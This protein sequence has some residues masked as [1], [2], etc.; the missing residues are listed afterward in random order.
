MV[1]AEFLSSG[2]IYELSILG[3]ENFRYRSAAEFMPHALWLLDKN[4]TAGPSSPCRCRHC[5]QDKGAVR[6]KGRLPRRSAARGLIKSTSSR[7]PT[8][9]RSSMK[10]S[11]PIHS[12][13]SKNTT[14]DT[15]RHPRRP[16]GIVDGRTVLARVRIADPITAP[17]ADIDVRSAT[18]WPVL[19]E[20]VWCK[21]HRPIAWVEVLIDF[22]PGII[23]E[24]VD[25]SNEYQVTLIGITHDVSISLDA[26]VPY[27]TYRTEEAL[28]CRIQRCCR[29][30]TRIKLLDLDRYLGIK[31][32][33]SRFAAVSSAFLFAIKFSEHLATVWSWTSKLNVTDHEPAVAAPTPSRYALRSRR[34][35]EEGYGALWW[36][37]ECI[38]KWQL[39]RLKMSQDAIS[40]GEDVSAA[41]PL[42]DSPVGSGSPIFLQI[43]SISYWPR[44]RRTGSSLAG[45]VVAG[46]I[47]ELVDERQCG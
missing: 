10:P 13:P 6:G 39:V 11:G 16:S 22:W 41:P 9:R 17:S 4:D 32:D 8:N 40:F 2:R 43:H 27:Q 46:M 19:H 28:V 37:P 26:M 30:K 34:S 15:P 18:A 47:Y 45:P 14:D 33:D 42:T 5:L 36:G 1:S 29:G 21:L 12:Y 31:M 35:K 44:S 20:L 23:K 38:K 25:G 3:R 7:L 24:D